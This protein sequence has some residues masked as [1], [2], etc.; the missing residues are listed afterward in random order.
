MRL[1]QMTLRR[2]MKA[3]AVIALAMVPVEYGRRFYVYVGK[4]QSYETRV[5][6][7]SI[8]H[9]ADDTFGIFGP[10]VFDA[11]GKMVPEH[12]RIFDML[13]AYYDKQAR[14]YRYAALHPWEAVEPDPPLLTPESIRF[15]NGEGETY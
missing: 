4:A 7:A 8:R 12:E 14:K 3:V 11:D 1:P 2:W 5:R 6:G 13:R 15:L 10:D 9:K